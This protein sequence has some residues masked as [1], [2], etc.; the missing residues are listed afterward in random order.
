MLLIV[1][2]FLT[3]RVTGNTCTGKSPKVTAASSP[4]LRPRLIG[5]F[6]NSG[7]NASLSVQMSKQTI[8]TDEKSLQRPGDD[9]IGLETMLRS[10]E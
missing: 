7:S 6:W 5:E 4:L 9:L 1:S 8:F 10:F 3:Q 2:H